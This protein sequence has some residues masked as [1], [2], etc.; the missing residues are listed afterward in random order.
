M[1]R[2]RQ[3]WLVVLLGLGLL[4]ACKKD[5]KNA[6]AP[7]DKAAESSGGA[8]AA[9]SDDLSYLPV[10]SEVVLGINVGQVQQSSL[11]KQFVEP[12]LMAGEAQRK[13]AEWKT[14]CGFDPM[15][16][17]KSVSLGAK[18][19]ASGKPDVVVVLHGLDKAKALDCADKS[20]DEV[21]KEGG[22]ITR[23]GDV[24]LVKDKRGE[25]M[26]VSFVNS[27]TAIMV[28]GENGTAAGVKAAAAG[29][30]TLKSSPPFLEMYK[31][32]NISDSLWVLING[33]LLDKSPLPIKARSIFGSFNVTDGLALDLR[34]QLDTPDA[35]T[36]AA[37]L[38]NSQ[39]KQAQAYVDKAEF[40]S[41]GAELHAVVVMS[42]QKLQALIS[43]FAGIAGAFMGGMGGMGGPGTP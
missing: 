3:G 16:S 42:S 28:R 32:V 25:S 7:G 34:V 15:T 26:A 11:W 9:A 12:K 20:K 39:A 4:A 24:V 43:Q 37:S 27:S 13:I 23:D 29:G 14:R 38:G 10:D 6:S 8:G 22:E 40:T 31:K 21:A 36:Q 33:K 30:S 2:I 1:V 19:A 5:D 41:D 35:A 18:Q 17:I